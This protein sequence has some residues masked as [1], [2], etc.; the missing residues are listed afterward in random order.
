MATELS[1]FGE[2]N[3]AQ[4]TQCALSKVQGFG[5]QTEYVG[6]PQGIYELQD[7]CEFYA[8]TGS[9][10]VPDIL[11][12]NT[13]ATVLVPAN[14]CPSNRRPYITAFRMVANGNVTWS[15]TSPTGIPCV[16]IQD[17]AGNLLVSAPFSALEP[18][19]FVTPDASSV[20]QPGMPLG[21]AAL[22]GI[23]TFTYSAAAKT[24]T[25]SAAVF[26]ASTLIGTP[27]QIIDGTGKG[28]TAW[29]TANTTTVLTLSNAFPVAPADHASTAKDSV[30]TVYY[31]NLSAYTDTTHVT[32]E[33]GGGTPF[34]AQQYDAD[35]IVG[36]TGA[37]SGQ[38][39][40]SIA[41]TTAGALT[42]N[43]ALAVAMNTTTT[44]VGIAQ[45]P[46]SNG[47]VDMMTGLLP[48]SALAT[49]IQVVVQNFSGTSPLGSPLR[50]E[51]IGFWGP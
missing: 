17:T 45:S 19:T 49:G 50:V 13:V 3:Y 20:L 27:V 42:L 10:D 24:V 22:G 37:G 41:N 33:N 34:A 9:A 38:A 43:G 23:A 51:V 2:G 46:A 39:R 11:P 26:V 47:L 25:A 32:L 48:I 31:Q 28:G 35:W 30:I 18:F 6:A 4:K 15:N 7:F 5:L 8:I 21:E 44:V 29:V 40:M 16:Q 36:I 14:R 12:A 1:Q